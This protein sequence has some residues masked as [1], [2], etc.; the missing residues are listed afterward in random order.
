MSLGVVVQCLGWSLAFVSWLVPKFWSMGLPPHT[1]TLITR[2]WKCAHDS[3]KRRYK[4]LRTSFNYKTRVGGLAPCQDYGSFSKKIAFQ[5]K[6]QSMNHPKTREQL[7]VPSCLMNA[8]IFLLFCTLSFFPTSSVCCWTKWTSLLRQKRS[9]FT[10]VTYSIF[11]FLLFLINICIWC[12]QSDKRPFNTP[13]IDPKYGPDLMPMSRLSRDPGR[14]WSLVMS[15]EA[16][17]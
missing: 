9:S 2:T 3:N 5:M 4:E 7:G 17:G 12:M 11:L 6:V 16:A 8:W 13:Q 1:H 10:E 15:L 14:P